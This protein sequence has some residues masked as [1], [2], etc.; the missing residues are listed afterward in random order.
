[1]KSQI[2]FLLVMFY[3]LSFKPS[4]WCRWY[5]ITCISRSCWWPSCRTI[6]CRNKQLTPQK[7]QEFHKHFWQIIKLYCSEDKKMN[8]L[9]FQKHDWHWHQQLHPV[10]C[11]PHHHCLICLYLLWLLWQPHVKR[12]P[13]TR[14]RWRNVITALISELRQ[15]LSRHKT[16]CS[17]VP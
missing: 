8:Q 3:L 1:M 12:P 17:R 7:Y 2:R 16:S 13:V 6:C 5:Q 10:H 4:H 9:T 11:Y 14:L 15:V